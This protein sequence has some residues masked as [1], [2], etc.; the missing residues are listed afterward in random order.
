VPAPGALDIEG[1]DISKEDLEE[2]L[3]VNP[4]EWKAE[5]PLIRAHFAQFGDR[6]P[7]KLAEILDQL[8]ASLS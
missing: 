4:E 6:L 5:V 1:L 2:L 8:D 3:A 7:P